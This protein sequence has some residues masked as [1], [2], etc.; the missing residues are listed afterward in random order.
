MWQE[1]SVGLR[2]RTIFLGLGMPLGQ[3][4]TGVE[5][6]P[7]RQKALKVVHAATRSDVAS[8]DGPVTMLIHHNHHN[9]AGIGD[10]FYLCIL[11]HRAPLSGPDAY[12]YKMGRAAWE[13]GFAKVRGSALM[14]IHVY[15]APKWSQKV[16]TVST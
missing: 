5:R 15:R 9:A 1:G 13:Q 7:I 12:L 8:I 16:A 2:R 14:A 10:R 3:I 11:L 4:L 6:K